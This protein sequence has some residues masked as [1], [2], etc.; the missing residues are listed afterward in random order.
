MRFPSHFHCLQAHGVAVAARARKL[1]QPAGYDGGQDWRLIR[2][3]TGYPPR[4]P[5]F[6]SQISVQ[7]VELC[8]E[9]FNVWTNIVNK[10]LYLTNNLD[11]DLVYVYYLLLLLSFHVL[12]TLYYSVHCTYLSRTSANRVTEGISVAEVRVNVMKKSR[13]RLSDMRTSPSKMREQAMYTTIMKHIINRSS[14]DLNSAR[15]DSSVCRVWRE[16]TWIKNEIK[17]LKSSST[18]DLSI[19]QYGVTISYHVIVLAPHSHKNN[20]SKKYRITC[21]YR[22]TVFVIQRGSAASRKLTDLCGQALTITIISWFKKNL[23]ANEQTR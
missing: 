11:V 8:I 12:E 17:A 16:A 1:H 6:L 7:M 22:V 14:G 9:Y 23:D 3:G 13:P 2:A 15:I 19:S 21:N 10:W 18:V 5:V 20:K 4:K